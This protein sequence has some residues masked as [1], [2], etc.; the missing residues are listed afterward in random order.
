[1]IPILFTVGVMAQGPPINNKIL[2]PDFQNPEA[3]SLGRYGVYP[4]AEYTGALDINIPLFEIN[5]KGYKVPFSLS[6]HGSGIK[7]NQMETMVGLG[8]SLSGI[9]IISRSVIG[10]PDEKLKGSAQ[11]IPKTEQEIRNEAALPYN[12]SQSQIAQARVRLKAIAEGAG[13]D[14][15]TDYY[16]Y[17][18]TGRSGK[19]ILQNR[20]DYIPIPFDPI[21]IER[22][23]I[24]SN[25]YNS[26]AFQI[27]DETG[28]VS[29]FG[30]YTYSVPENFEAIPRNAII[31]SW[32]LDKISIPY[33]NE[34]IYFSYEDFFLDEETAYQEQSFGYRMAGNGSLIPI[35][36]FI[37]DTYGKLKHRMKFI[38]QI[39]YSEGR[40]EFNYVNSPNSSVSFMKF[41]KEILVYDNS[42]HLVKKIT[43][44]YIVP[45][46]RVKLSK[47]T[48][49]D[50][51]DATNSG[52][53]DIIYNSI[54]F[55]SRSDGI[56]TSDFWGYYNNQGAGLIGMKSVPRSSIPLSATGESSWQELIMNVGNSNREINEDVN[57][58][59][60]I[61]KIVYPT[62]GYTTFAFESNKFL[63]REVISPD[64]QISYGGSIS[65]KGSNTKSEAVYNFTFDSTNIVK[66]F[67]AKPKLTIMF[68]PPTPI[69]GA[70]Q[71]YTQLVTLTD[72]TT[73]TVLLTKYHDSNPAL[74]LTFVQ[75]LN[76]MQNHQYE[77]RLLVYG[78]SN[79]VNG[80]MTSS[81]NASVKWL[82]NKMEY[83]EVARL[84]GGLRI[85]KVESYDRM[86]NNVSSEEYIYGKN[87]NSVGK[88]LFDP[89]IF[90]KDYQDFKYYTFT[91]AEA[92]SGV[93]TTKKGDFWER[94]YFGMTEYSSIALNGS[95]VFYDHVT[96]ITKSTTSGDQFKEIKQYQLNNGK[97]FET[98]EFL[99]SKNYGAFSYLLNVPVLINESLFGSDGKLIKHRKLNY[100]Y[101][102]LSGYQPA[103]V[104]E[105][106]I[107]VEPSSPLLGGYIFDY[108]I[109]SDFRITRSTISNR[110]LLPVK[111]G[112]TE[113]FYKNGVLSD[114]TVTTKETSYSSA[115]HLEPSEIKFMGSNQNE[116]TIK[117]R[118]PDDVVSTTLFA[119]NL[120]A[121]QLQ[122]I[123]RL[124]RSNEHRVTEPI[125]IEDYS[126]NELLSVKRN[127]YGVF[128]G[129]TLLSRVLNKF[130]L[131]PFTDV[132]N[133]AMYDNYGNPLEIK[134]QKDAATVYL[135]GYSGQ[136]PIAK[137]ENA[138]YDEVKDALNDSSGI[139]LNQL[140]SKTTPSDSDFTKL[141]GLRTSLANAQIST[142]TYKPLVG[143]T[144]MTDPRGIT[145]Y[146]QYDGFQRL[147]DVLDFDKNVLRNY[148]YHYRP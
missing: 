144:S 70:V 82:S 80:H 109:I 21:K 124:N 130:S 47:V 2:L 112:E 5:A 122:S 99:N 69:N 128:S 145:E 37:Y 62:K 76:L 71:M 22:G 147:K 35:Q 87:G 114:S 59:E 54:H 42:D 6:F 25:L 101:F 143:M 3:A 8:W 13:D 28:A 4:T 107:F 123:Q 38:K 79:Y 1:M 14:T 118:Y 29:T 12:A 113:Y 127:L 39:T 133:I 116:R 44:D 93:T 103:L 132:M 68:G 48:T 32:Y 16:F 136:Y 64:R 78:V 90:F 75:D 139:F 96:K 85:K 141:N 58:A 146:Y 36:P 126:N 11:I 46:N 60:M 40:V 137:V 108:N 49:V 134:K 94:K 74:P 43:L 51:T 98:S 111:E 9:G 140:T 20:T 19:F 73:N 91:Q 53:Y 17:N 81:I 104:F 77:L 119:G 63:N 18:F 7:L 92:A 135:W 89:S 100:D 84:A 117:F 50:L 125:Q 102:K 95:P 45:A 41:L 138:T 97:T 83:G 34:N 115:Y 72:L 66:P 61:S 23:P 129:K 105:Q 33:K 120:N 27:T 65:G 30:S 55:P 88:S 86:N 26:Y 52:S 121:G 15:H 106:K 148:Q 24:S 31:S 67:S 56:I 131:F 10:V 142:Y 57:Q 110:Q